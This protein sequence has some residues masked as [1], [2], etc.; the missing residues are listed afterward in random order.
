MMNNHVLKMQGFTI[1]IEQGS[2]I[3]I[4]QIINKTIK[5]FF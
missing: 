5:H 2:T 4:E 1:V 3:V